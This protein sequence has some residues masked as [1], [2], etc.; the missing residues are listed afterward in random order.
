MSQRQ[1]GCCAEGAPPWLVLGMVGVWLEVVSRPDKQ[2]VVVTV[3][4]VGTEDG[5]GQ[6]WLSY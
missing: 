4:E 1:A 5:M 2:V 6:A 3:M